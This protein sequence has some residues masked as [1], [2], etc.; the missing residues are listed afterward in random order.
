[1]VKLFS[2][3]VFIHEKALTCKENCNRTLLYRDKEFLRPYGTIIGAFITEMLRKNK[4]KNV[5][6]RNRYTSATVLYQMLAI[7]VNAIGCRLIY[8]LLTKIG[9]EVDQKAVAYDDTTM[10]NQH[11]CKSHCIEQG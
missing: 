7:N 8:R 5:F 10:H 1:M 3:T 2:V 6:I 9:M 11:A 4:T